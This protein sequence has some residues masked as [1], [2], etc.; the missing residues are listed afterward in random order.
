MPKT[1][2]EAFAEAAAL[3]GS[4]D[5]RLAAYAENAKR[6]RPDIHDAYMRLVTRLEA[7]RVAEI[8]P[9]VGAPMP[10]FILPDQQ[11]HLVTLESL[12]RNGPP[13]LTL[14]RGHAR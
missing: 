13:G 6:L 8:G 10:D 4:I 7:L 12:S 9:K 1:R 14:N 11:G 5:E 2:A 3:D